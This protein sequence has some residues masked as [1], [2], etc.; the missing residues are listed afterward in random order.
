MNKVLWVIGTIFFLGFFHGL[1]GDHLLEILNSPKARQIYDRPSWFSFK[2]G[3]IHMGYLSGL[4]VPLIL[5][6]AKVFSLS[7]F[8]STSILGLSFCGL[9]LYNAYQFFRLPPPLL[10]QHYHPH[11]HQHEH[12]HQIQARAGDHQEPHSHVH[13]FPQDIDKPLQVPSEHAHDHLHEH[14]HL[15]I[16]TPSEK[17]EHSHQHCPGFSESLKRPRNIL[18]LLTLSLTSLAFSPRAAMLSLMAFLVG[19]FLSLYLLGILFRG[20]GIKLMEKL[21]YLSHFLLGLTAGLAGIWL[22]W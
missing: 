6:K 17:R 14:E 13:H 10:H 11:Q 18:L 7:S 2:L 8:P 20:K 3:L 21:V 4:I 5:L 1:Q 22:L 16:H 19:L 12:L 15:H 9:G